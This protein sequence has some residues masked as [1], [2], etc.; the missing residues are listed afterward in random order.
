MS[1]KT[2][3]KL[4]ANIA[5]NPKFKEWQMTWYDK[6]GGEHGI[7]GDSEETVAEKYEELYKNKRKR[8]H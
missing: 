2:K 5:Y 7:W 8:Q 6:D 3:R 4:P 1:T